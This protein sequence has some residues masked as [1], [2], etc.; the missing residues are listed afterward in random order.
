METEDQRAAMESAVPAAVG[1]AS[2]A[3]A[4]ETVPIAAPAVAIPMNGPAEPIPASRATVVEKDKDPDA[5]D[6]ELLKQ[7]VDEDE[8][9][10]MTTWET[11]KD[12][13][14][15]KG[16]AKELKEAAKVPFA[17]LFQYAD[18]TDRVLMGVGL[19]AA[20]AAGG[21]QIYVAGGLY[22]AI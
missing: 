17:R 10:Q 18:L 8:E 9:K 6:P 21:A 1:D 3:T 22:H 14:K 13:F 7:D 4:T 15:T 20:L 2:P 16:R 5:F 11:I 19:I 12:F